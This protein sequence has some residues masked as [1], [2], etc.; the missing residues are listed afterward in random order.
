M[1]SKSFCYG[2]LWRPVGDA[3]HIL[4][5]DSSKWGVH[6]HSYPREIRRDTHTLPRNQRELRA[7]QNQNN[8]SSPPSCHK[9]LNY[10]L[11]IE[12]IKQW[13][14]VWLCFYGFFLF[15]CHLYAHRCCLLWDVGVLV[16]LWARLTGNEL[17]GAKYSSLI[18]QKIWASR[19]KLKQAIVRATDQDGDQ[20]L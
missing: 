18:C 13:K 9:L 19:V 17:G 15:R 5:E 1:R 16:C 6:S 10:V 12:P 2:F 7:G 14:N 4:M 3:A 20:A 11:F 8:C